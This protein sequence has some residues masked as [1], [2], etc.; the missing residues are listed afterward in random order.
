MPPTLQLTVPTKHAV[1]A[2]TML[3]ILQALPSIPY[4]NRLK[5]AEGRSNIDLA[6]SV[7]LTQW[8]DEAGP[9]D[10]FLFVDSDQTFVA[11]DIDRLIALDSDV[12][13]GAYMTGPKTMGMYPQDPGAFE[14]G[15]TA[16]ILYGATGFMLIRRPILDRVAEYLAPENTHPRYWISEHDPAVVP[17]FRNRFVE[18]E[19]TPGGPPE[20][21]G[22]DYSFCWLIRRV[23]GSLRGFISPTI[24][25]E[26]PLVHY[27]GERS[28]PQP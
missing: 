7:L 3:C 1:N 11:A 13:V 20:W 21:L 18:S 27:I 4:P 2:K 14:R 8:F 17:F 5:I 9:E 10:L 26:I 16:D 19:L 23:G 22:E 25:H 28:P 6:R 12:A 24:G 15:Q